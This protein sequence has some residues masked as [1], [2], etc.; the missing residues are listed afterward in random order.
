MEITLITFSQTGNTQKVS[1]A[2]TKGFE[3]TSHQVTNYSMRELDTSAI[4]P[5]HLIGIGCPTFESHAPEPVKQ[6]IQ[7]MPHLKNQKAFVYATCG[8]ASGK[9]LYDLSRLLKQKGIQVIGGL[10]VAGEIHHPAPCIYGKTANRPNTQDLEK[11][12]KFA[13]RLSAY[14]TN[15]EAHFIDAELWPQKQKN[16]FYKLVGTLSSSNHLIRLLEPKPRINKSICKTC[17]LCVK[18]CPVDN[19]SLNAYPLLSKSCIRCYRCINVCPS[20]AITVNWWLGNAVIY[21]LWN[22]RFMRWFGEYR[23]FTTE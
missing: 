23:D 5:C 18:E 11:A 2:L 21:A 6:F 8:G 9:V 7:K 3:S 15:S 4:E 17:K 16:G 12:A 20:N 14:L 19:I 13:A 1:E 22:E 10:I